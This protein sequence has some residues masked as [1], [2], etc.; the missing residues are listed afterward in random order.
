MGH[1]D[2][3]EDLLQIKCGLCQVLMDRNRIIEHIESHASELLETVY[4]YKKCK[5]C[6]F[7]TISEAT[8][9]KH[10]V[11]VHGQNLYKCEKCE[12]NTKSKQALISHMKGTHP[13]FQYK[14]KYKDCPYDFKSRHYTAQARH[15]SEMHDGTT[16][17]S[18]HMCPEKFRRNEYL[19]RHIEEAHGTGIAKP[20]IKRARK[21]DPKKPTT[22]QKTQTTEKQLKIRRRRLMRRSK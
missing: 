21:S 3:K 2:N 13:D 22:G 6:D 8:F 17:F 5:Q 1:K 11:S 7:Q 14:C 12:V 18:C 16:S 4:A 15:Y 10:N 20:R 9:A 19:N